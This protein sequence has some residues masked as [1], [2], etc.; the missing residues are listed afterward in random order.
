MKGFTP[1]RAGLVYGFAAFA[2]G[3][4][5]GI[6]R[7]IAVAPRI[8]AFAAVA[9]EIPFMLAACLPLA[10]WCL[11]KWSVTRPGPALVLG[12]TGFAALIACEVLLGLALGQSLE[13][14]GAAMARPPGML[15]LAG[16]G[17]FALIPA[18]LAKMQHLPRDK[19]QP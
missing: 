13:E 6:A 2:L 4:V 8:G 11:R 14:I 17:L 18:S 5:L 10:G 16:Q 12:F 19:R 1:I 7:T 9:V 3:F 15:G